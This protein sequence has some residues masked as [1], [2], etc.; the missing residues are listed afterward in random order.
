VITAAERG[1]YRWRI[2]IPD[3]GKRPGKG[4][5]PTLIQWDVPFHP[6]DRLPQSAVSIAQVAATHPDPGLVRDALARVGL[7]D[8]VRI[9]YA[10][11][12]RLAAMLQTPRGLATL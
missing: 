10:R 6:A 8:A 5:V 11:D 12:S 9:T 3:D 2:T 4:V 1:E 7:A